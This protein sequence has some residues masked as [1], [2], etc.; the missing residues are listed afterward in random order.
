MS[1]EYENIRVDV[2]D[3]VGTIVLDRPE[4]LNAL[5][6]TIL[7]ELEAV[8]DSINNVKV[9]IVTGAG[10]ESFSAGADIEVNSS[11][12]TVDQLDKWTRLGHRLY[13]KIQSYKMPVIAAINGYCFGGGCELA[14][15]CDLRIANEQATIG[16]T[17]IDIGGIPGWGGTQRLSRVVGIDIAKRMIFLGERL[18]ANQAKNHG[19]V[20]DVVHDEQLEA[21]VN[22][23]AQDIADQPTYALMVGKEA[24][25]QTQETHLSAGLRF[26]EKAAVTFG[27]Q[28]VI[29]EG[30]S[31]FLEKREPD[32]GDDAR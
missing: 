32:F 4:K 12:E 31:A 19:L 7:K 14:L 6:W 29:D 10:D 13:N 17:E 9:L 8:I 15:A 1:Q 27:G 5:N 16:Q 28:A 3:Q 11:L 25:N 2:K 23:L 24:V 26:E 30:T 22:S 21:R 20:T 18:D